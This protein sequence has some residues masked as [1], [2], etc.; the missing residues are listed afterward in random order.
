M[1]RVETTQKQNDGITSAVLSL[2]SLW[3][4]CGSVC[5]SGGWSW[6]TSGN[7][8]PSHRDVGWCGCVYLWFVDLKW[9]LLPTPL[10]FLSSQVLFMR[11]VSQ[12]TLANWFL[13]GI[14]EM[15]V[16]RAEMFNQTVTWRK[17][18]SNVPELWHLPTCWHQ[19]GIIAGLKVGATDI[20]DSG[21]GFCKKSTNDHSPQSLSTMIF[22][23]LKL[24]QLLFLNNQ[25]KRY[26][27]VDWEG[28]A[29]N[30][31]I[32]YP[33]NLQLIL[34]WL[35]W[36]RERVS[37][38]YSTTMR[39]VNIVPPEVLNDCKA[40]TCCFHKHFTHQNGELIRSAR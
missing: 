21:M 10:L 9:H 19:L 33:T 30:K 1:R 37:S 35:S 36:C 15:T 6:D 7:V 5:L 26:L 34:F 22:T 31:W 4:S 18:H 32:T 23:P 24:E 3:Q 14:A 27:S 39:S 12:H 13:R 8:V 38:C 20:N 17:P 40:P 16:R 25:F 29:E 28:A 11:R 2:C